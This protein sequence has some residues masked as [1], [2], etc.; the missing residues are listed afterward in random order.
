MF[1]LRTMSWIY[2][3]YMKLTRDNWL[4]FHSFSTN[5]SSSILKFLNINNRENTLETYDFLAFTYTLLHLSYPFSW[6]F[7][8][9]VASQTF[10]LNSEH[11]VYWQ[12]GSASVSTTNN[13]PSPTMAKI[14]TASK[15]FETILNNQEMDLFKRHNFVVC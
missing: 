15:N 5:I 12:I 13:I 14:Q 2:A 6:Y 7:F 1:N 9:Y 3:V 8:P 11:F 4:G 10:R